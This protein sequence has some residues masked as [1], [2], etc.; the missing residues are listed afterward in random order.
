MNERPIIVPVD[1]S[2]LAEQ[3]IPYA[4]AFAGATGSPLL[5]LSVRK[6]LDAAPDGSRELA[7]QVGRRE[8]QYYQHYLTSL[9]K[10]VASE[11]LGVE[12]ELRIGNPADEILRAIEQCDARLLVIATHGRSGLSRWRYGSVASRLA[13]EAPVPTL[14]V[15]S[16]ALEE[17]ARTPVV[18]RILVPLDGS[19]LAEA[20]LAPAQELAQKFG[21]DIVL[22]QVLSWAGQAFM[23]DV[24]G[25]TVAEIDRELTRDAGEYLEKTAAPLRNNRPV[26]TN[27][28]H[29]MPAD[30]LLDLVEK[31]RIDLVVM[32]SHTRAGLARAVLGSVADRMLQGKAPVLLVRPEGAPAIVRAA[33][34][35]YCHNCGRAS[36][37]VQVLPEE[38]CLR[39]GQHLYAC[40][41]CVYHDG[42]ACLL[43]RP[44]VHDVY[45]GRDCPY[46][47]FRETDRAEVQPA[48]ATIARSST[49]DE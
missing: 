44:E 31:E 12:T 6:G 5:L 18:Q 10:H 34:G 43:Q 38:R 35:R 41:N 33:R 22:A 30:T 17:G 20:A 9:T 15:A 26:K 36:P 11:G 48:R 37:Y 28:L 47:Q 45:P 25:T 49:K 39:C 27:V 42:I 40:A 19:P 7:D 32:A 8:E 1:G 29:G 23:F 13:R 3:A 14:V 4:V 24:P 2:K 46:F 16:K 21:A